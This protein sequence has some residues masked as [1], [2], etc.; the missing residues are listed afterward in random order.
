[1]KRATEPKALKEL[2]HIRERM[3]E[4]A[5]KVGVAKYYLSL[6]EASEWLHGKSRSKQAPAVVREKPRKYRA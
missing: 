2:H 3:F 6:N 4:E 1:M 5:K